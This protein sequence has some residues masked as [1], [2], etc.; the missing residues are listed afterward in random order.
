MLLDTD[1]EVALLVDDVVVAVVVVVDV[2]V[3]TPHK[4]GQIDGRLSNPMADKSELHSLEDNPVQ[5][6]GSCAGH[7]NVKVEDDVLVVVVVFVVV[8]VYTVLDDVDVVLLVVLVVFWQL[9]G[10]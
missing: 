4:Y 7:T 5:R 1:V 8:V 6:G 3:Q 9:Q 2:V 10:T